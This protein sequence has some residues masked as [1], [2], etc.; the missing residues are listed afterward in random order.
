MVDFRA[1]KN[2]CPL[3]PERQSSNGWVTQRRALGGVWLAY[4]LQHAEQWPLIGRP[5]TSRRR[6][7]SIQPSISLRQQ[8]WPK[9]TD[10]FLIFRIE[11]FIFIDHL[12][13][14]RALHLR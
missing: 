4:E 6:V 3:T 11:L 1:Q 2:R 12:S 7:Q 14:H 9:A 5:G 13:A 10:E 8:Y